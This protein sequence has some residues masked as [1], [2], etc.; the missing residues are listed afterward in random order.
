[1][2]LQTFSLVDNDLTEFCVDQMP[3]LRT[4]NLDR[5][6]ISQLHGVEGH[7]NLEAVSLREQRLLNPAD[8]DYQRLH[9]L[10]RTFLGGFKLRAFVP[11]CQ[12]MNL[13]SLE[14]ASTGLQ[15]LPAELGLFCRNLR[16][17][18]LNYNAVG[19]VRP[20]AGLVQLRQLHIAGNRLSRLRRTAAILKGLAHQ[21]SELDLRN[22]P[23]TLGFYNADAA[24]SVRGKTD[25]RVVS[26]SLMD[27]MQISG[28][29]A[30]DCDTGKPRNH[31]FSH[32]HSRQP[33]DYLL[34][35]QDE[36]ADRLSRT[37]LDEDT[38][39]RRRVYEMLLLNGCPSLTRLDGLDV[40]RT[41]MGARDGVWNRL[42]EL[43]VLRGKDGMQER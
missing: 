9:D 33:S 1:M 30:E 25:K 18:N 11:Q 13:E 8:F 3:E 17:L 16:W 31:I 37:R 7:A 27:I 2:R 38:E 10:R 22:N 20:L 21:L 40:D 14:L 26:R 19:D 24:R 32:N 43:G 28:V 4:L 12:F 34:P 29:K 5:N 15:T 39:L 42:V 35:E 6:S 23:L 36:N 41:A